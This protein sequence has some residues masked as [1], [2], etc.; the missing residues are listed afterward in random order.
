MPKPLTERSAGGVAR[1]SSGLERTGT[2]ARRCIV[3]HHQ[4]FLALRAVVVAV[5]SD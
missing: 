1:G 4:E 2:V 5:G 3:E